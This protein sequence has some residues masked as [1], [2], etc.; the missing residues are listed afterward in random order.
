[1]ITQGRL[2]Q[3][4]TYNRNTGI[5][6]WNKTVSRTIK[7]TIAGHTGKRGYSRIGIN[8]ILYY[9]HRLAWLYEYGYTPENPLD[10]I[11]RN[12]LDNRIKN[13]REVSIQCNLRN[14]K[15]FKN[16][17]SGVTGVYWFPRDSCWVATIYINMR[18]IHLGRSKDF[19]EA[20]CHRLAAEQAENWS[21]CDSS[22]PAYQYVRDNIQGGY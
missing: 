13:L 15:V 21:G 2:K 16:N 7:G 14:T 20:V 1:M 8:G 9:A 4:L 17:T 22:S 5:F 10:H 3:L 18:A 12:K 19:T 6:I 11:N